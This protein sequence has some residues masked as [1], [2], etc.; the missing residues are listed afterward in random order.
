MKIRAF[1]SIAA[2]E[3]IGQS[4]CACISALLLFL[5]WGG[6]SAQQKHDNDHCLHFSCLPSFSAPL[7]LL[8]CITQLIHSSFSLIMLNA[9]C[10]LTKPL[11]ICYFARTRSSFTGKSHLVKKCISRFKGG[12]IDSKWQS[13]LACLSSSNLLTPAETNPC[14]GTWNCYRGLPAE[15]HSQLT[16]TLL[17]LLSDNGWSMGQAHFCLDQHTCADNSLHTRTRSDDGGEEII[18]DKNK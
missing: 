3:F 8:S 6:C 11:L 7:T 18:Q 17:F 15:L 1:Y 4:R 2:E 14:P 13:A 16:T 12:F 5:W 9:S 10:A